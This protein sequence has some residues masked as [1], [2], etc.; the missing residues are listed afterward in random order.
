V[1]RLRLSSGIAGA[2]SAAALSGA[3]LALAFPE[4]GLAGLAF[5]APAVLIVLLHGASVRRGAALGAAFGLG[6]F[7]LLLYW[8]SVVG[9]VAY[10]LLVALQACF[11]ALFGALYARAA[12]APRAL[13]LLAAPALW[14]TVEFL[15]TYFPLGGFPW[16]QLA[17]SQ[18]DLEHLL[19]PA[20]FAGGWAVSFIVVAAG[21]ALAG[22]WAHRREPRRALAALAL[23]AALFAVPAALPAAT[24]GGRALRVAIVQ[25][26]VPL[27]FQGSSFDKDLAIL[28]SHVRLTESLQ[29]RNVDLV[30]WPESSVGIDHERYP[31]VAEAMARAA[32]AAG[33]PLIVGGNLDLPGD[34]YKVMAFLVSPTGEVVDRYQKTHLVPFG[35]YVP[36]RRLLSWIPMLEQ[37]PRDA[38][39]AAD[40]VVFDIDG[41][42]V[43]TVISFE[44]DFGPLVRRRVG[45]G[46]RLVVVATNT[47]TWL[48]TWASAQHLAFSEVRAAENGTWVVHAALSGISGFVRPDGTVT[49]S[50]QLYEPAVLVQDLRLSE[51]ATFYARTGEWFPWSCLALSLAALIAAGRRGSV[52]A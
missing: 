43:A 3:C 10:T 25:G 7:G 41:A 16:G 33:A 18:H 37:V 36:G 8:I 30:V 47:S 32:R 22:A 44:G 48:Y 46:A 35:E 45:E 23:A 5:V 24:A 42:P 38:V 21:T 50:S 31:A 20:R 52:T 13:A 12:R 26:N 29:G 19:R 9:Y 14:V 40:P 11:F 17:Q 39:A 34:R 4:P 2:A 6:F 49:Q 51:G 28:A 1:P 27:D 15:R